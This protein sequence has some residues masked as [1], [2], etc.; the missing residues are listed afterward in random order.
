[1]SDALQRHKDECRIMDVL[2][3]FIDVEA[4]EFGIEPPICDDLPAL[5]ASI[6]KLIEEARNGK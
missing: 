6:V 3:E 1:M 4:D 2:R 5:V